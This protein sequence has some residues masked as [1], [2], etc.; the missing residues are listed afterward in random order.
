MI[1]E[2]NIFSTTFQN[3]IQPGIHET[4]G[5]KLANFTATFTATKNLIFI[6][7]RTSTSGRCI[8]FSYIMT[9]GDRK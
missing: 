4:P 5:R 8:E 1:Y 3:K 9:H 6:M 2:N 7:I